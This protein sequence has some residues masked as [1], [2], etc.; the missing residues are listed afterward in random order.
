E[1]I[2]YD[3]RAVF[4]QRFRSV[5]P[6]AGI[7]EL[8]HCVAIGGIAPLASRA[9]AARAECDA[10]RIAPFHLANL[11]A[12]ALDDSRSFVSQNGGWRERHHSVARNQIGVTKADA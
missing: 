7:V 2:A 8:R 10:H 11:G 4:V 1:E 3:V 9:N 5:G 6:H 12:D